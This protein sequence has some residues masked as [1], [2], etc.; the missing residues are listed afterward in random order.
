MYYRLWYVQYAPNDLLVGVQN[1]TFI[2]MF[3]K[4]INKYFCVFS[5]FNMCQLN[6]KDITFFIMLSNEGLDNIL[7]QLCDW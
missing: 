3:I 1:L 4:T 5:K 7:F 2:N 6:K